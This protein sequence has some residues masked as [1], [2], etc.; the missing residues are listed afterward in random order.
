MNERKTQLF[1]AAHFYY[2][3]HLTMDQIATKLSV[4]RATV[5]RLL[6]EAR[7]IGLV[8]IRINDEFKPASDL[9]RRIGDRFRVKATV[10]NTA[11]GDSDLSRMQDVAR[12]G[13]G[14]LGSLMQE[15]TVLAVAWGSTVGEVARQL[16]VRP[17]N[18]SLVVQLNG[19]GNAWHTGI[20]YSGAILGKIADAFGAQMIHFPVPALFDRASTKEAMWQEESVRSVLKV[21][22]TADIALFGIG[23]FGGAIPSHVYNG[24]YF[25]DDEQREL[26]SAGVV[27]DICTVFLRENGTYADLE[28]N[29]RSTG[30]TP[31][32]LA[33]IKRRIAVVSGNHRLKA[34][35]AALQTGAITDLVLDSQL[36]QRLLQTY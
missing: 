32:E 36:A 25:K 6:K 21:Q 17:Q 19:A 35:L 22:R 10:V 29:Q 4:S 30:P 26:R 8:E 33:R 15:G 34:L 1:E 13:G 18:N 9:S 23:A 24:G 27:G 14:L 31:T 28:V 7:E 2:L 16:S 20:P 11:P 3:Q 12:E 5:S